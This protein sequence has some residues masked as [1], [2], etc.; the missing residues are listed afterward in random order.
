MI[1]PR[2]N[3][4]RLSDPFLWLMAVAFLLAALWR[5]YELAFTDSAAE[6]ERMKL[7]R[8]GD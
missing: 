2:L 5:G 4:P 8:D 7:V 1:R 3:P 6:R